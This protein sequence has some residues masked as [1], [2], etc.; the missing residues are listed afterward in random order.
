[1]NSVW[2]C[3]KAIDTRRWSRFGLANNDKALYTFSFLVLLY[4]AMFS[5]VSARERRAFWSTMPSK[6]LLAALIADA[7][8]GTC[9]ASVGNGEGAPP[10]R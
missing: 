10:L 2:E 5:V 9:S 1:M 7:L 8:T 6:A 3:L 4:F